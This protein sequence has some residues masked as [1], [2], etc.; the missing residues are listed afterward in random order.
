MVLK[1]PALW[2]VLIFI[3]GLGSLSSGMQTWE[4][5]QE[6][7]GRLLTH[8]EYS[9]AGLLTVSRNMEEKQTTIYQGG[10]PQKVVWSDDHDEV[11]LT[12]HYID[13]VL[14]FTEDQYQSRTYFEKIGDEMKPVR[15]TQMYDGG[16]EISKTKYVYEGTQLVK[17]IDYDLPERA[18]APSGR[19]GDFAVLSV[20]YYDSQE[21]PERMVYKKTESRPHGIKSGSGWKPSFKAGDERHYSYDGDLLKTIKDQDGK[22]VTENFYNDHGR[23]TRQHNWDR[24]RKRSTSYYDD[25]GRVTRTR[26]SDGTSNYHYNKSRLTK[27][28]YSGSRNRDEYNKYG[29]VE[30]RVRP[31]VPRMSFGFPRTFR[32]A[33]PSGPDMSRHNARINAMLERA[34]A[35]V[36]SIFDR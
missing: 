17:T 2:A 7:R 1:K 22:K 35:R 14:S 26:S 19:D 15:K 30:K 33:G 8:F 6:G 16:V 32:V 28:T 9:S 11:V 5:P 29:R 13:G 18:R 34:N 21:R 12:Y 24:E 23:L 25:R 3:A 31:P 27:V 10:E 20:T 4:P 36:Q